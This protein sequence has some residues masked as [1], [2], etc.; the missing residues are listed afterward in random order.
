[1]FWN[2]G[3]R[4]KKEKQADSMGPGIISRIHVFIYLRDTF[5]SGAA[6][7]PRVNL[8]GLDGDDTKDMNEKNFGLRVSGMW[9]LSSNRI[10]LQKE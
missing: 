8:N 9:V 5:F 4:D 1:M 6:L 10:F 2:V 3:K 7:C